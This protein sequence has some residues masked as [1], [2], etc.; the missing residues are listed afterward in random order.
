MRFKIN[1]GLV[2]QPLHIHLC[3]VTRGVKH[4]FS[5]KRLNLFF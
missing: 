1:D 5:Y 4:F 2:D 3:G